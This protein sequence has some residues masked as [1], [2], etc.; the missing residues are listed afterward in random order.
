MSNN[1]NNQQVLTTVTSS[2][3]SMEKLEL[4]VRNILNDL[5]SKVQLPYG[6]TLEGRITN[7]SFNNYGVYVFLK[8]DGETFPGVPSGGNHLNN[9][10]ETLGGKWI[11]LTKTGFDADWEARDIREALAEYQQRKS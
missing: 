7:D 3:T 6:M 1:R 4:K 2:V 9:I 10:P 5:S 8:Q 11:S